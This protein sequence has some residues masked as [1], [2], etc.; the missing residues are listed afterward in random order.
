M[1]LTF[2]PFGV[3]LMSLARAILDGGTREEVIE[4]VKQLDVQEADWSLTAA[5]ADYFQK[6]MYEYAIAQ[7]EAAREAAREAEKQ[8]LGVIEGPT[9]M[10]Y[11]GTLE[12]RT[13]VMKFL[14]EHL[15]I[16]IKTHVGRDGKPHTTTSARILGGLLKEDGT[17]GKNVA[18][19]AF[20]D[21]NNEYWQEKMPPWLLPL[22]R[23]LNLVD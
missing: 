6:E 2:Q 19:E 12:D 18:D 7:E 8:Q 13:V 16:T 11:L 20:H 4:L 3:D 15:Y 23:S 17:P 9:E 5:L 22:L 14:P 1:K 21:I 10:Q